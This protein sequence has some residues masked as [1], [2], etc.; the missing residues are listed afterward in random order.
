MRSRA[1]TP[2]MRQ[3]RAMKAQHPDAI[4]F[5]RVGDFYEMFYEDAEEAS[6]LLGLVLTSRNNGAAAEVPLA[7]IPAKA[8][9]EYLGRLLRL[10][11]RVAICE[12]V[13]DPAEA[14]G[15]VRREVVETVTPGVVFADALLSAGRPHYVAA[16]AG[17]PASAC[18]GLAWADVSTGEF[19]T[20]EVARDALVSELARL[21]VREVLLPRDWE[22]VALEG[23]AVTRTYR[24]AWR[25]DPGI[26]RD[27]LVRHFRVQSLEGFGI[28]TSASEDALAVAAA[29]ALLSYLREVQPVGV[30]HLRPPRMERAGQA[31]VL[32]E[33]TRRNLELI[34]P[35]RRDLAGTSL[36]DVLDET[37]TPMGARTLRAWLLRPLAAVT[38]VRRRLD[39]V[40]EFF[41]DRA[42]REAVRKVL[43]EIADL[44]RLSAKAAARRATPRDL[45]ALGSSLAALPRLKAALGEPRAV[46][47]REPV[48]RLDLVEDVADLIRRSIDPE[49]PAV[50]SE[51]GVIREGYC[52][53]L[54]EIR[55][56]R[57]GA[58]DFIAA[59]QARE[60][61]RTGIASLKIGYNK[62]FGYYLEVTRPNLDRVPP[63]Y[64]RRQTLAGA[65]RF[66]TPEL[67]E[68]ESKVLSAEER[69]GELEEK[70]FREVRDR[71]GSEVARIQAVAERVA[72]IDIFAAL[73]HV[74]EARG[75]VRPEIDDDY[76]I[77][78]EAGRHPVVE[79]V[80]PAGAF[81]PNDVVLDRDERVMILTGPNMAG[82]STVLRQVGLIVV[83][84]QMGS[85]VP[86]SR[87]RLGIVDR[88][89]TR[90]GA[91]DNIAGG[92]STFMVEMIETA[93][94]LNGATDRSLVLL[95]E[96]GRGTSTYDGVSIAWAVSEHLHE[97]IGAKTIFATH[98]HELTQITE[99]L[100]AALA[101]NVAVKEIG[102]EVVFLRRLTRGGADRSYGIHVAR[103]AGIPGD[104]IARAR[105]VLGELEGVR[106]AAVP[107]LLSQSP[108]APRTERAA[109][110]SLFV[111]VE[112]AV[113]RQLR[114][115]DTAR[116]TPLDAL[117]LL[118]RLRR[119][120]TGAGEEP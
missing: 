117:N 34:E 25:F 112:H 28:P 108:H 60:R 59:L 85:F 95:D 76:R 36:L 89:F 16:V 9:D 70:A 24:D 80:L 32:D 2:L 97:R 17:D 66:V 29:G 46:T 1:D 14:K 109:Q 33:M 52:A 61:E 63:D 51:G 39:A 38:P 92:Q 81:V 49:A 7:G 118:E 111:P 4:L 50:V 62:V 43:R 44:E 6:R 75:Y 114:D 21:D 93:A 8:L 110:L 69:I 56:A 37:L 98:Y 99:L 35:L 82:K 53:E 67:R 64:E 88:L 41:G 30:S 115:L 22:P 54:D 86:A 5:F 31:L 18:V 15:L 27:E 58:V 106:G 65:E 105:E 94:I 10:G 26:A 19:G 104:V 55:R 119:A 11:R 96:I 40:E 78:I 48:E 101:Y 100:P 68:W 73:A 102:D 23:A 116:L 83:M 120:A 42:R 113:V 12:Q 90:V 87:A 107:I 72:E 79:A 13:E 91:S 20:A 45:L 71:V 84:A 3:Y 57:D 47:L 74:A 103:L 77:E